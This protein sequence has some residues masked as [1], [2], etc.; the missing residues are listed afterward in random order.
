MPPPPPRSVPRLLCRAINCNARLSYDASRIG[1]KSSYGSLTCDLLVFDTLFGT[2]I[3]N[4]QGLQVCKMLGIPPPNPR[5]SPTFVFRPWVACVSRLEAAFDPLCGR[6]LPGLYS[7]WSS[8]PNCLSSATPTQPV[9]I[10]DWTFSQS[11]W[12]RCRCNA[13]YSA[14]ISTHFPRNHVACLPCCPFGTT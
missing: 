2:S 14:S 13:N 9:S 11:I 12:S 3:P 10:I 8:P 1:V 5:Y 4:L 7:L 6:R